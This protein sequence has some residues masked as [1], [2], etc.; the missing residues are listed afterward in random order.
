MGTLGTSSPLSELNPTLAAMPPAHAAELC[1]DSL[2]SAQQRALE[3]DL[4]LASQV[5]RALLPKTDVRHGG[6]QIHYQYKSKG[7]VS[8]DY[9]DVIPSARKSAGLIFLIGDVSGKGVAASLLMTHLHATFRSLASVG[10]ELD[11]LIAIA[12]R[13][14]CESTS[15][16]LYATLACGRISGPG[17]LEIASA[18]HLPALHIARNGVKQIGATGLPLGLFPSSSYTINRLRLEPGD[19]LILYADGISEARDIAGNEFGIESIAQAAKELH[20]ASA[21]QLVSACRQ[22]VDRFTFG[23]TQSDDQTL[24]AIHFE[25]EQ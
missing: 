25:G 17:E 5:Q 8:G 15:A 24:M 1:L 16:S 12:N 10:L 14:F 11:Q 7:I 2:T 18:G 20:G 22:E 19:S 6:W 4:I 3:R 21:D 9:C 23:G 13:L